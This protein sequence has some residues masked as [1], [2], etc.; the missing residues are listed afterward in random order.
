MKGPIRADVTGALEGHGSGR[1][2]AALGQQLADAPGD[3]AAE[4]L[5]PVVACTDSRTRADA[6]LREGPVREKVTCTVE[7][8]GIGSIFAAQSQQPVLGGASHQKA[9]NLHETTLLICMQMH[10]LGRGQFG[11]VW[12]ARWKGVEVAMKELHRGNSLRARQDM[13][14]E[15]Q[16]LASLRHPCIIALFGILLDDVSTLA[17]PAPCQQ[18]IMCIK[19]S[20][21]Q[22]GKG[23]ES[24]PSSA[25]SLVT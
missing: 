16:T 19:L 8:R 14:C 3:A 13:L 7:E 1:Q 25:S 10:E 24:L 11:R 23:V 2:G 22:E 21:H 15:A 18:R 5:I 9:A 4:H 17:L 12:L 6:R 20:P